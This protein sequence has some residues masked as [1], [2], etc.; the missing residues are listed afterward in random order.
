MGQS[1][2]AKALA[3]VISARAKRS[4]VLH[5]ETHL[6]KSGKNRQIV[7]KRAALLL[8]D[9]YPNFEGLTSRAVRLAVS[10]PGSPRLA[11]R[12]VGLHDQ[13]DQPRLLSPDFERPRIFGIIEHQISRR[14]P[15]PS[16]P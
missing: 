13:A 10:E 5:R 8:Q 12:A 6:M 11:S 1:R 14:R 9:I 16:V 3:A 15:W 2:L 7:L 4:L